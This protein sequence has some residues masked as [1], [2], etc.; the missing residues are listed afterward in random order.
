MPEL[1][2]KTVESIAML[3]RASGA[4][5]DVPG[6]THPFAVIPRDAQI[7]SLDKHVFNEHQ[8][9]PERIKETVTVLDA[10]SFIGYYN[11]FADEH[12]LVM[13]YEPCSRISGYLDYHQGNDAPRWCEHVVQLDL[14]H[15]VEWDAWTQ[16]NN[17]QFTQMGF[18]EFLEQHAVEISQPTPAAIIDICRDLQGKSEVEFGS[19]ARTQSGQI[20][21]RYSETIRTTVGGGTVE[22]PEVFTIEIPVY[23]GGDTV[24]IQALLRYRIK[25]CK[26]V[27]WYTLVRADEAKRA[28][29]GAARK[30]IADELKVSIL[31]GKLEE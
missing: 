22:V 2:E 1:T 20:Q 14:R 9:K 3:A 13:A 29:F 17:K 4:V 25:E 5:I 16:G 26:L 12:S 21:L 30:R 24:P 18:A 23:L 31:N 8:A 6:G 19:G 27:L 28:A 7:V 10:E 15:S 11:D